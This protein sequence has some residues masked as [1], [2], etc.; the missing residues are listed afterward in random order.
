MVTRGGKTYVKVNDYPALRT[1]FAQLL[2]EVQRI[3]STGD[4][5]AAR[6][7]VETYGV[8]IDPALHEEVRQRYARLGIAPYKGFINPRYE[9]VRAEDGTITDVRVTYGESYTDQMLRYS[10]DYSAL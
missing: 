7:L 1:L 8:R 5:A 9:A 6:Q 10:R 4:L 3:K 2:A